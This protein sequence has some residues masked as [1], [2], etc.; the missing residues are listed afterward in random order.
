MIVQ[1]ILLALGIAA[2]ALA[3]RFGDQSE[4]SAVVILTALTA[5]TPFIDHL[6]VGSF[7]WA[8]AGLDFLGLLALTAIA[9]SRR[10]WWPIP[11]AGFQLIIVFTHVVAIGSD[12]Y[13]WTA[14]TARLVAWVG[15]L[16]ALIF[17]AYE[18]HMVRKYGLEPL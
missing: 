15:I 14:V 6:Q 3:V 2:A 13:V 7:R 4:R 18:A 12:F 8:E 1:L 17:A 10:R 5:V 11:L 9:M 16:L